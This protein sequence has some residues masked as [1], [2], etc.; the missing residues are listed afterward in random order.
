MTNTKHTPGPW[1]LET[2]KTQIG[3]CHKIGTFPANGARKETYACVYADTINIGD[4]KYSAVGTEL[5]A[6]AKL[7]AAAPELLELLQSAN[8]LFFDNEANYPEGTSGY[9]F[10]KKIEAAIKKATS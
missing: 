2:V 10:R 8:S 4:E 7:I 6:N 3:S 5:L 9:I 1:K